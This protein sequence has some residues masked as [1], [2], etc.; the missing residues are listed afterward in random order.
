MASQIPQGVVAS[1]GAVK[2]FNTI[3]SSAYT[4]IYTEL[5]TGD[6]SDKKR[7][8]AI[9]DQIA[10]IQAELDKNLQSWTQTTVPAFYEQG[11]FEAVS[12]LNEKGVEIRTDTN[13]AR[14]H[15][16]AIE[17]LANDTY[18]NIAQGMASIERE[19][20]KLVSM[21]AKQSLVEEIA[22]GRIKGET[23]K[24]ITKNIQEVLKKDGIKSL[25]DRGGNEWDLKRYGEMLAR[26][27]LTQAHNSGITN[28]M[29]E[30]GNDLVVVS[31]HFGSCALCSPYEGK[32]LSV[33]GRNGGYP[34]LS[35]AER[36][37]LFHPNCRHIITP[38]TNKYLDQSV[39]WD[40]YKQKYVPYKE[41]T[42]LKKTFP[43][44]LTHEK[45]AKNIQNITSNE[46]RKVLKEQ[47]LELLK[48][49]KQKAGAT[50][51]KSVVVNPITGDIT[52]SRVGGKNSVSF[53][54]NEV[55]KFENNI[56]THNHPSDAPFSFEDMLTATKS[57]VLEV[58]AV[59]N[60]YTYILKRP[61]N[62]WSEEHKD[63]KYLVTKYNDAIQKTKKQLPNIDIAGNLEDRAKYNHTLQ[64]NFSNLVG[65][66]YQRIKTVQND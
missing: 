66:N 54:K 12:G 63:A 14:F 25:V 35:D 53:T 48:G 28:K 32:I 56:L 23:R 3:L 27:K 15:R 19:A 57:N 13:F 55:A 18:Q 42:I 49:N 9:L 20:T 26:T 33:S 47:E 45:Y 36:G 61:T 2:L 52:L 31:N 34:S 24:E 59:G 58:R 4:D 6:Y 50:Y 5:S 22:K 17:V 10:E 46:A 11:L 7:R 21:G 29:V 62:G 37:G 51:E 39:V 38:Y 1:D 60:S 16:E 8:Q 64:E 30:N 41:Q 65:F 43:Q 40:T 44:N